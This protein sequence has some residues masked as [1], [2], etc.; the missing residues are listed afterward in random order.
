MILF[1][2]V[3]YTQQDS[4]LFDKVLS[5]PDKVFGKL[6]QQSQKL[7]NK[8]T[9]QTEKYL[10]KLEKQEQKLKHKLWRTDSLKAKELFG[11]LEKR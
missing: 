10:S 1:C 8:L 7:N 6:D 3:A 5:F 4:T 2:N 9:L 11:N